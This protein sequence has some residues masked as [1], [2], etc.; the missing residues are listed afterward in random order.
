MVGHKLVTKQTHGDGVLVQKVMVAEAL[1]IARETY[2]AILLDRQYNGPVIV[3]S[4]QGGVDIEEVA[5]K[6]PEAI[7]HVCTCIDILKI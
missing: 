6:T 3:G 2:F 5:V 1:D 7:F 4:S